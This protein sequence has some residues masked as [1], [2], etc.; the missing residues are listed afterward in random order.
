MRRGSGQMALPPRVRDEDAHGSRGRQRAATT[1][2]MVLHRAVKGPLRALRLKH[3]YRFALFVL[4]AA[5]TGWSWWTARASG[6]VGLPVNTLGQI[7]GDLL[8]MGLI[9]PLARR[10]WIGRGTADP[11][12]RTPTAALVTALHIQLL[13]VGFC[14]PQ[15]AGSSPYRTGAALTG[16]QQRGIVDLLRTALE[17][18]ARVEILLPDPDKSA[19][20]DT[21]RRFG[22]KPDHYRKTLIHLLDELGAVSGAFDPGG[23]DVRLYAEPTHISVIRCDGRIWTSL[24]LDGSSSAPAYLTLDQGSEN[25]RAL[26]SYLNRLYATARPLSAVLGGTPDETCETTYARLCAGSRAGA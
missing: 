2:P 6:Y 25:A 26:Q 12:V 20:L 4:C 19:G 9:A 1:P 21:A 18:D 23:L 15:L 10:D 14:L 5:L 8:L 22:I 11:D 7:I 3:S 16:G 17:N 13:D 24:H